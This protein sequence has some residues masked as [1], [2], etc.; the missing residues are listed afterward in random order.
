MDKLSFLQIFK[1]SRPKSSKIN[2][3]ES[4]KESLLNIFSRKKSRNKSNNKMTNKARIN[5][6]P[7]SMISS[8]LD[9]QMR[10]DAFNKRRDIILEAKVNE[11][12]GRFE[13]RLSTIG[14]ESDECNQLND[15]DIKLFSMEN[16]LAKIIKR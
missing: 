7:A 8:K 6:V 1:S 5:V 15:Q 13:A 2:E 14:D 10:I 9:Y 12:R 11:S 16:P 3:I 4:K